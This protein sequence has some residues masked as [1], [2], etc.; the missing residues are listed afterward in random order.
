MN[1]VK[2]AKWSFQ[3]VAI[4]ADIAAKL[5]ALA[6]GEATERTAHV[7]DSLS[8]KDLEQMPLD[9]LR[10]CGRRWSG[11]S[12]ERRGAG[13]DDRRAVGGGGGHGGA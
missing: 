13:A 8:P 6:S 4:M 9:Q 3:M 5:G 7:I 11:G 1:V 2:P 12:G 10:R